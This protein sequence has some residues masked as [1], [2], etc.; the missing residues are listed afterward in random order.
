MITAWM[1]QTQAW[2]SLIANREQVVDSQLANNAAAVQNLA[3]AQQAIPFAPIAPAAHRGN[4][5]KCSARF[6]GNGDNLQV[7]LAAANAYRLANDVPDVNAITSLPCLLL[8]QAGL[9]WESVKTDVNTWA[10]FERLVRFNF[11]GQWS[12]PLVMSKFFALQHDPTV[13]GELFIAKCRSL[14]SHLTAAA[15]VTEHFQIDMI[16]AKLHV[17]LR[18]RIARSEVNNFNELINRCRATESLWREA[19]LMPTVANTLISNPMPTNTANS[20]QPKNITNSPAGPKN[21][22]RCPQHRTNQHP[23][24]RCRLN[25]VSPFYTPP[26]GQPANRLSQQNTTVKPTPWAR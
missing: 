13:T 21:D 12:N 16:Y 10:E 18:G 2:M 11:D 6:N 5:S 19:G 17:N 22:F 20:S 9:W 14:L 15:N 3:A 24:E 8:D 1:R 23:W 26:T 7:F 25:P 4:L